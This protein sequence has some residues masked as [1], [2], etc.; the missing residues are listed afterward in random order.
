MPL[1]NLVLEEKEIPHQR[2]EVDPHHKQESLMRINPYG[3]VPTIKHNGKAL[4]LYE[5]SVI[6]ASIGDACPDSAKV[7]LECI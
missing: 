4:D 7:P 3:F 1:S 2:I 6:R 5:S